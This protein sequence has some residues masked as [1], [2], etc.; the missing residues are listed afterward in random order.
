[1]ADEVSNFNNNQKLGAEP[2][3]DPVAKVMQSTVGKYVPTYDDIKNSTNMLVNWVNYKVGPAISD[4]AK[5]TAHIAGATSTL[6]TQEFKK[7]LKDGVKYDADTKADE[8]AA[9][10]TVKGHN[11]TMSSAASTIAETAA[12]FGMILNE[13]GLGQKDAEEVKKTES[14]IIPP[15]APTDILSAHNHT[16]NQHH[17]N[18]PTHHR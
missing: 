10:L 13:F 15:K 1:M 12:G 3:T 11:A 7:G 5:E 2:Q 17:N 14:K 8:N 4:A 16:Q 18:K 9:K 6:V